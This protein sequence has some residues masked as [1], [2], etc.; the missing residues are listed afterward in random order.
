M[1]GETLMR[2]LEKEVIISTGSACSSKHAGNRILENIGL[3]KDRIKSS[4]R[5]SFNAYLTEQEVERAGKM[6]LQVYNEIWEK[7]K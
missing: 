3:N 6:I 5:I 7:V 1:N 2:A 4:V